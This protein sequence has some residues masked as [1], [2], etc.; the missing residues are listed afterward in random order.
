MAFEKI[1]C[2][3]KEQPRWSFLQVEREAEKR[4]VRKISIE[5]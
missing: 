3:S 1:E 2:A 4:V 5:T